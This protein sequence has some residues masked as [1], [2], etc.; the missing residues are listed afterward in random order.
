[1]G[2][3]LL[4]TARLA[5]QSF[6]SPGGQLTA[7]TRLLRYFSGRYRAVPFGNAWNDYSPKEMI[8]KGR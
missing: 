6:I 2:V 1:L 7:F 5:A 3:A 8:K 4:E